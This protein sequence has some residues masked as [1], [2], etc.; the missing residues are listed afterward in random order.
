LVGR[1]SGVPRDV[2]GAAER[3]ACS[4]CV[5]VNVGVDRGD[6]SDAHISY[7]YDRDVVFTRLSFPHMMSR[8]NVPPGAGSVQAELYFS[9]KYMPLER[10]PRDYLPPVLDDLRRCGV[11]RR[12]DRL[13]F[14]E[15]RVIPY[16]NVIFDLERDNALS[17]VHGYLDDIGIGYCGRYG[18]WAYIW[19]DEAFIS[20]EE[21]V[22]KAVDHAGLKR[23]RSVAL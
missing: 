15:V 16:A 9:K 5:V 17:T 20:G 11:L 2:R 3:L 6:L 13:L 1:I 21:A 10:D 14:S 12:D 7:F 19:T 23:E 22:Q 18:L 4:T 8:N